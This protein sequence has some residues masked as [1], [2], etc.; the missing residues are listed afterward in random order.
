LSKPDET[1]PPVD[2]TKPISAFTIGGAKRLHHV[3]TANG[4]KC[5]PITEGGH[6]YCFTVEEP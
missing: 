5:S 2:T 4:W 6:G 1:V 3:Y